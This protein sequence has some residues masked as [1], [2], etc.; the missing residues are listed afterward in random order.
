MNGQSKS[1]NT[2]KKYLII[3]FDGWIKL[4]QIGKKKGWKNLLEH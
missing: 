3:V 2:K 1:K 4:I